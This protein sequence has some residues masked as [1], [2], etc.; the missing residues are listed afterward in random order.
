M[1]EGLPYV[2]I[3]MAVMEA[4]RS[5][6]EANHGQTLEQLRANGGLDWI[7][8]WCGLMGRPLFPSPGIGIEDARRQVLAMVAAGSAD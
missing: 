5:D 2:G 8:L 1:L 6:F 4:H 3:G 7:E